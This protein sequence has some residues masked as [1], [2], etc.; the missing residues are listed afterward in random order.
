[1]VVV[2][3][4]FVWCIFVF[5]AAESKKLLLLHVDPSIDCSQGHVHFRLPSAVTV[6][7]C[8]M[9]LRHTIL[10]TLFTVDAYILFFHAECFMETCLDPLKTQS[11]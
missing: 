5:I 3:V 11:L 1:M 2:V 6:S 8:A 9:Y 7:G 4:D 10:S